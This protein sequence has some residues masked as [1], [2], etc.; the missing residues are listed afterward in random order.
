[1]N[2]ARRWDAGYALLAVLWITAGVGALTLLISAAARDAI[3]TSRN[4]IA[5]AQA[6][7]NAA[8]CLAQAR[9]VLADALSDPETTGSRAQTVAWN[10]LD[11]IL[12]AH[13][14]ETG[15]VVSVRAVGSR[16]DV[17]ATD[18]TTLA[19]LLRI[20]GLPPGRADTLAAAISGHGPFVSVRD[21]HLVRGL[22]AVPTIDSVLDVEP[23]AIALNQVPRAILALLPGFRGETIDAV[24][25]ERRRDTPI[26]TFHELSAMLTPDARVAYDSAFPTLARTVLL[27]PQAWVLTARSTVGRP[28]VTVAV[29]LRIA[30][31]GAGTSIAR[32]RS[33]IE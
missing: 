13:R 9:A 10:T 24:L 27:A 25:E 31:A 17:N 28:P 23:G 15:C 4:R 19:R 12:A 18:S 5:L 2:S 3:G 7:W 21:L 8:G 29:E 30:R 22:E 14:Q 1:M 20:L 33:W 26:T 6:S 32:Y 16:L 11:R